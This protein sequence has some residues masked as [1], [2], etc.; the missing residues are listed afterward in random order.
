MVATFQPVPTW[1]TIAARGTIRSVALRRSPRLVMCRDDHE[2]DHHKRSSC[3]YQDYGGDA[4]DDPVPA[5]PPLLILQR[6][7][8]LKRWTIARGRIVQLDP[9]GPSPWAAEKSHDASRRL[10]LPAYWPQSLATPA[11]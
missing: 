4:H 2:N 7:S 3:K 1:V 11:K 5:R 9:A 6:N 8:R 10:L